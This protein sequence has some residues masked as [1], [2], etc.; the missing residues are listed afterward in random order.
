MYPL[1]LPGDP[2]NYHCYEILLCEIVPCSIQRGLEIS[3][4][5]VPKKKDIISLLAIN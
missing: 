3:Y 1:D 4:L 2:R 5:I